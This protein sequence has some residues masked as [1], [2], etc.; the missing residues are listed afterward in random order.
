MEDAITGKYQWGLLCP[1]ANQ[2]AL[3]AYIK[4]ALNHKADRFISLL[5]SKELQRYSACKKKVVEHLRRAIA[6]GLVNFHSLAHLIINLY[7]QF[8]LAN[9][10]E[11]RQGKRRTL[12]S[13]NEESTRNMITSCNS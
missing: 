12:L 3:T 7:R 2:T 1:L 11:L 4:N 8:L 13:Q 6:K 5:T 10:E 9:L